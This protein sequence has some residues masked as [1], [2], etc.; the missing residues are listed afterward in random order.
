MDEIKRA[1][2]GG[3]VEPK[4]D[5]YSDWITDEIKELFG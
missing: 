3:M 2:W 5:V 1:C 4:V